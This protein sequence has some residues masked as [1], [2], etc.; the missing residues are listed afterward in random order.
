MF[1][2]GVLGKLQSFNYGMFLLICLFKTFRQLENACHWKSLFKKE[3]NM[4]PLSLDKSEIIDWNQ[5]EMG[6]IVLKDVGYSRCPSNIYTVFSTIPCI[7]I[8]VCIISNFRILTICNLGWQLWGRILFHIGVWGTASTLLEE[9]EAG[10]RTHLFC[11]YRMHICFTSSSSTFISCQWLNDRTS[12]APYCFYGLNLAP[13][14]SPGDRLNW[15][16]RIKLRT[17]VCWVVCLPPLSNG[18][19][20]WPLHIDGFVNLRPSA[21]LVTTRF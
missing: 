11:G 13:A 17:C 2:H 18:Y 21:G 4:T 6:G 10:S 7:Y 1:P 9:R 12:K 19:H 14:L 16:G 5:L 15:K 3:A 20:L 8:V